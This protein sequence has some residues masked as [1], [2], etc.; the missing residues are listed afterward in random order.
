MN[1]YQ[2]RFLKNS[3]IFLIAIS[4]IIIPRIVKANVAN[5]TDVTEVK[6]SQEKQIVIQDKTTGAV[7]YKKNKAYYYGFT[8]SIAPDK[9]Q[10][11]QEAT[12]SIITQGEIKPNEFIVK[13]KK[14]STIT[15]RFK[16]ISEKIS[17]V[18]KTSQL[19]SKLGMALVKLNGQKDYFTTL[20]KLNSDP[21]VEYVEPNYI[22][23]TEQLPNDPYFSQQ[24][25][26]KDIHADLAWDKVDAAKRSNVTI[27]ILDTGINFSHEDLQANIVP[28][29]NFVNNNTNPV[30][31]HGHGTHVA[32]IAAAVVNNS[33]GVAGV[34][35]GSKIMPVKVLGDNGS[36]DYSSIINGIKYAV[37]HGAK[38]ISM[39][40]G[41]PGSSQAMQD[42]INDALS[43]G[44]S[45]VAA[46]GNSNGP[47][48]FPGNCNGVITVGAIDSNHQRASFSNYGPELDVVAP[49]VG[50]IS[51]TKGSPASYT[52]M[53]GTSMA[54]P[55]VS[56][57]VALVKAANSNLSSS[58][59][60]AIINQSTIDLGTAGFDNYF[61]NGLI[62]ANKAVDNA[63]KGQTSNPNP[64][65][66]PTPQPAPVTG[67]NLALN[68][69][70][71]ASSVE[72]T[73][74]TAVKAVD[75]NMSTRWASQPGLD[76]QNI[77]VDLGKAYQLNKIVLKWETAYAK[78][79]QIY[80][81]VDGQNW[82]NLYT[83]YNGMGG[84]N[85]HN[86]NTQARY[87]LLYGT[88]R[89]TPYGYSLWELEVYGK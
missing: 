52:T 76:A 48:V 16:S 60:N 47:V 70:A 26:P 21:N 28:G 44:V 67:T 12:T 4:L 61:G 35:G 88:Q 68:K 53:S 65:P 84:V 25:G 86:V 30:D 34:S 40:L 78:G 89:G 31:N 2:M 15:Q 69:K 3:S 55:F 80:V 11:N 50:I 29:Y 37:D 23:H 6:T 14:G 33:K 9:N 27:A 62:D 79:Y 59:V 54:T 81:S 56:G 42:A 1:F 87:V 17:Q 73:N 83:T 85:T 13:Y 64:T 36:G 39:S 45:V 38:V 8:A 77:Y 49:G 63:L 51:S 57:V 32:G 58:Q 66:A 5:D 18:G 19:N 24:W 82:T 72:G 7:I 46:S 43:R 22:A 74:R 20:N 71:V 75:G 41:G 10:N